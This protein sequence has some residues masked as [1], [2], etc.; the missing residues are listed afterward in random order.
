MSEQDSVY[1]N[2]IAKGEEKCL[3]WVID[4]G[5]QRRVRHKKRIAGEKTKDEPLNVREEMDVTLKAVL[6]R[7]NT[8]LKDQFTGL[9]R[10]HEQFQFLL[11]TESL[12]DLN[13]D[14]VEK[15][16]VA[17][18]ALGDFD[19]IELSCEIRLLNVKYKKKKQCLW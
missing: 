6:D 9:S 2:S 3:E 5:Q 1:K 11:D 19:G 4:N 18:A 14:K 16:K 7:L 12:I 10:L 13:K 15:C 8:E 17:A